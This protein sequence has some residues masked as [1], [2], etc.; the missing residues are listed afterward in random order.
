MNDIQIIPISARHIESFHQCLESVA[1]E[2][3]YLGYVKA[4]SLEST[5]ETILSN[6]QR[7][8]PQYVAVVDDKVIGWCEVQQNNGEGFRHSGK[9]D[10]MG[11]LSDYRGQGIGKMLIDA[12]LLAAERFGLERVELLVYASNVNAISF[13][14]KTGFA[15]EG[16]KRKARKLDG[17]YDDVLIMAIFLN[18]K[19][20]IE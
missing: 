4:P 3:K 11:I 13:Y 12:T 18:P 14:E 15:C 6:I 16:T 9:L 1:G 20:P 5:R 7:N 19:I 17:E 10:T 8:F 2:R